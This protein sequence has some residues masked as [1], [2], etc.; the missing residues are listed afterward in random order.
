MPGLA[1]YCALLD[2]YDRLIDTPGWW[3]GPRDELVRRMDIVWARYACVP[4]PIYRG[5]MPLW[6]PQAREYM[7]TL[8]RRRSG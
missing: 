6:G 2:E 1:E 7:W 4:D 3:L 8:Y 5:K